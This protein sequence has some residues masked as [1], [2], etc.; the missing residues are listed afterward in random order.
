LGYWC[1][2]VSTRHCD[3]RDASSNL[4]YPLVLLYIARTSRLDRGF[5][6]EELRKQSGSIPHMGILVL[7]YYHY[8]YY[9]YYY[10]Y[11]ILSASCGSATEPPKPGVFEFESQCRLLL[12]VT[13]ARVQQ[14]GPLSHQESEGGAAPPASWSFLS[15]ALSVAKM[16][17][18]CRALWKSVPH[19]I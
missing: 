5:S 14:T 16:A 11:F 18:V 7:L 9:Y 13:F 4:A 19:L 6:Q 10:Y 12:L 2:L 15:S 1:S 3:W 8:H 17:S